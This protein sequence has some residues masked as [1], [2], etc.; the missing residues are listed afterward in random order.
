[1]PHDTGWSRRLMLHADRLYYA[2]QSCPIPALL[3]DPEYMP[4]TASG[5]ARAATGKEPT[6]VFPLF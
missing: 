1:M 3:F 2:I 6:C 5:L 4:A